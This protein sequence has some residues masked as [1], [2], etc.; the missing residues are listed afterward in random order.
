MYSIC[1][2]KCAVLAVKFQ[3][4]HECWSNEVVA[5]RMARHYLLQKLTRRALGDHYHNS[6]GLMMR[7]MMKCCFPLLIREM[8]RQTVVG[9]PQKAAQLAAQQPQKQ[10][11]PLA[12]KAMRA[13][14]K[15][16]S[17]H[18]FA[19][20]LA[21]Q[22]FCM[23]S[24]CFS[25]CLSFKPAKAGTHYIYFISSCQELQC[26]SWAITYP[27]GVSVKKKIPVFF[28]D[29]CFS[30]YFQLSRTAQQVTLSLTHSLTH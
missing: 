30:L 3:Y 21:H 25:T 13:R 23:L 24:R 10:T 29:K 14:N 18:S 1:C 16:A 19:S 4:L 9:D 26:L 2:V 27:V 5:I 28:P 15:Q 12:V 22:A 17:H 8:V 7:G 6:M 20:C 11:L